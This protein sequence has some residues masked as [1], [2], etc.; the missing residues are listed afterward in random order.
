F[1]PTGLVSPSIVPTLLAFDA[2]TC[3]A[4]EALRAHELHSPGCGTPD[5]LAQYQA[6]QEVLQARDTCLTPAGGCAVLRCVNL[7]L[8]NGLTA[9]RWLADAFAHRHSQVTDA[10]V[11][12]WD[13]AFGGYWPARTQLRTIR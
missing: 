13:E 3:S 5:P 2:W 12:T 11:L 10:H 6:A 7:C 9:P 1:Q 8:V 4:D